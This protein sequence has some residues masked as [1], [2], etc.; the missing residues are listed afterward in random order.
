MTC[1]ERFSNANPHPKKGH[2]PLWPALKATMRNRPFVILLQYGAWGLFSARL[3]GMVGGALTLYYICGGNKDV[4]FRVG[5][6]GGTFAMICGFALMPFMGWFSKRLGKRQA[7]TMGAVVGLI[8][9]LVAPL[10]TIPGHPYLPMLIGLIFVPLTIIANTLGDALLPDICDYDELLSGQR[11]EGLFTSVLAFFSK[12]EMSVGALGG[13]Y[14]LSWTGFHKDLATQSMLT[15]DRM[16]WLG[17]IPAIFS[18]VICLFI[19]VRFPL[20]EAMMGE[21]RKQ[22]DARH[23]AQE[24]IQPDSLAAQDCKIEDV[25]LDRCSN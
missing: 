13:G 1:R 20:T 4:S 18:A 15:L 5:A 23:A 11:R 3:F 17:L 12:M 14:L 7:M 21:V 10:V 22:L 16:W 25:L 6:L 19:V 8:A 24:P 9:A 2:V